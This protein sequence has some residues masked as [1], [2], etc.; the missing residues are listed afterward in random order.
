M[1]TECTGLF[2]F[3]YILC[4]DEKEKEPEEE[5]SEMVAIDQVGGDEDTETKVKCPC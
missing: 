3:W 5:D 1:F 2:T 4:S